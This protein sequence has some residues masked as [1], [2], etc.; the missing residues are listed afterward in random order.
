[1]HSLNTDLNHLDAGAHVCWTKKSRHGG[2]GHFLHFKTQMAAISFLYV[3]SF[4]LCA[5][6]WPVLYFLWFIYSSAGQLTCF[7]AFVLHL[8]YNFS[9]CP[10]T[11]AL[12]PLCFQWTLMFTTPPGCFA[13]KYTFFSC[14]YIFSLSLSRSLSQVFRHIFTV[15]ISV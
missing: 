13:D 7:M 4:E 9:S 10:F 15:R 8:N 11:F 1:M 14:I 3:G 5:Q 6:Q 12:N 2:S